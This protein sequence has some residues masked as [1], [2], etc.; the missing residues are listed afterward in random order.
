MLLLED[1]KKDYAGLECGS[2]LA[3]YV[4]AGDMGRAFTYDL[5][6]DAF[7][8][9]HNGARLIALQK[10]RFWLSDE[11]F[12]LDAGAFVALLEYAADTE[13]VLIGKPAQPFFETALA[14]LSISKNE[15]MMIGDDVESDIRGAA[16]IGLTTCLVKT[17]KFRQKDLDKSGIKPD[18][19]LESISHLPELSLF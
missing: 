15:V 1:A 19:L 14:D 4:V 16:A 18:F 3:D 7:R 5:L 11:G 9:L 6:N 17:G 12:M 8:H 10:N 13:S 2:G